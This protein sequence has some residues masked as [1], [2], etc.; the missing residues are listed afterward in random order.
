MPVMVV[1]MMVTRCNDH[2]YIIGESRDGG[3]CGGDYGREK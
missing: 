2:R 1:T 3:G